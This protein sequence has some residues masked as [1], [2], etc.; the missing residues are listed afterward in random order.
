MGRASVKGK[1]LVIL[2]ALDLGKEIHADIDDEELLKLSTL[3][4]GGKSAE[5]IANMSR[6]YLE[7]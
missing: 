6:E 3:Q 4:N 5:N 1:P 2:V 7:R